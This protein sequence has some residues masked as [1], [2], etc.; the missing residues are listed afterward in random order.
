M[1]I[2]LSEVS[3]EKWMNFLKNKI[4]FGHTSRELIGSNLDEHVNECMQSSLLMAERV[5]DEINELKPKCILEI[6]CSAGLNCYALQLAFPDARVVGIEPER[7]AIEVAESMKDLNGLSSLEFI[8]GIGENLPLVDGSVD[9][10]VCHTVI[11]HVINVSEVIQEMSRVLSRNG[12]AHLEAP[13]YIW[14][15]EPHL[16]IW[17]VP[18]LGKLFVKLTA[19]M[20]GKYKLIGFLDH[21]QFV[22]PQKLEKLFKVNN[23]HF[24]N[25]TKIKMIDAIEGR[26]DVRKYK[27]ASKTLALLERLGLA[28]TFV[29][30]FIKLGLYPSVLYTI[31]KK[32]PE[33]NQR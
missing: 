17:T 27:L 18:L 23:L 3:R 2:T 16:E 30:F 31:Y 32:S 19:T 26:A 28:K 1:S 21:L 25:R 9:L 20:Q 6:G 4:N 14:P 11:E 29:W 33:N 10:I 12:V 24:K 22:T 7:E 15:Y 13:N 8:Q 5:K